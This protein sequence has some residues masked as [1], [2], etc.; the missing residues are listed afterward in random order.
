M[1]AVCG[2]GNPASVDTTFGN[3][4]YL[5][6]FTYSNVRLVDKKSGQ[7]PT[8][9]G[10]ALLHSK[11]RDASAFYHWLI[12]LK[13]AMPSLQTIFCSDQDK[14]FMKRLRDTWPDCVHLLGREHLLMNLRD[15][16]SRFGVRNEFFTRMKAELFGPPQFADRPPVLDAA[17][18]DTF[19]TRLQCRATEW[20]ELSASARK[21]TD[22]ILVRL[23]QSRLGI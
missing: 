1:E 16:A 23:L 6:F 22:W 15:T 11:E 2:Y 21:L 20:C 17:D 14:M 4:A 9:T 18:E 10:P 13:E 19:T 12:H 3:A 8:F 5:T 7:H